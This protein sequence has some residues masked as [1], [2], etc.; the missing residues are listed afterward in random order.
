MTPKTPS[1]DAAATEFFDDEDFDDIDGAVLRF[2]LEG[3]LIEDTS[4]N[5]ASRLFEE[6]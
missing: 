5:A 4:P 3:N 2:D 1:R 6:S